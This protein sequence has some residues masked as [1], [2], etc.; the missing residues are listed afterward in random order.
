M[1]KENEGM[2]FVPEEDLNLHENFEPIIAENGVIGP[3]EEK[4]EEVPVPDAW[5]TRMDTV[6][7]LVALRSAQEKEKPKDEKPQGKKTMS[8]PQ[9]GEGERSPDEGGK[10]KIGEDLNPS[11]PA[12][13]AT[14]SVKVEG[15]P[16]QEKIRSREVVKQHAPRLEGREKKPKKEAVTIPLSSQ[17]PTPAPKKS[18]RWP[19][20]VAVLCFLFL[21]TITGIVPVEKIPFLR[22]LAYA[23]GFTK[24]D[25]ARMSFLRALLTWTDKTVGFSSSPEEG[26]SS[27]WARFFG[28]DTS[29][30]EREDLVGL[31]ARLERAGGKTSLIDIQA[32]NALQRQKGRA[33]DA[34]KNSALVNP[35][36]E[37]G[38]DP[39]AMRDTDVSVHTEANQDKN[40]V[41]FGSDATAAM[42]NFQDGYD[43]VN[44][45][46][47]LANP[48]IANGTPI[49]WLQNTAQRMMRSDVGLGGVNRGLQGTQV[50]W[51]NNTGG[52]GSGK[53][54]KDL[55]FAWITS[56]MAQKTPNL[57]L[58]KALVDTGFMGADFPTMASNVVDY[59]GIQIDMASFQEDQESWREYLEWEKKCKAEL[60]SSGRQVT[61]L[62]G[63][64]NNL[65]RDSGKWDFPQ[66]CAA[67][68][69]RNTPYEGT[70]FARNIGTIQTTC[71]Q[72]QRAYDSLIDTCHMSVR[73]HQNN[74]DARIN[75]SYAGYWQSFQN[76]CQAAFEQDFDVWWNQVKNTE[77]YLSQIQNN[78]EA[79]VKQNARSTYEN[80]QW[81][82]DGAKHTQENF[83]HE[84]VAPKIDK[85][86]GDNV[87]IDSMVDVVID[88]NGGSSDYFPSVD[89]TESVRNQL[90]ENKTI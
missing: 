51:G 49:D 83:V 63:D 74:C 32:L 40:D 86:Q 4:R 52:I 78:G 61:Q 80:G 33:L 72:L 17:N 41:F 44:T 57:M 28:T 2:P 18:R 70:N 1:S 22:N 26:R 65:V 60:D 45:L 39:A 81:K 58:K 55:Y 75:N 36:S 85:N 20:V 24:A 42:R 11:L 88:Q 73:T 3:S 71:K 31:Q 30:E 34:I 9:K 89:T 77:P 35:G 54:Q 7:D 46:K 6:Q 21:G 67:S 12:L 64:F 43:S 38:Q 90:G 76:Q 62:E 68:N 29:A 50:N 10:N 48:Y 84:V 82:I 5:A 27:L 16:Q 15:D 79:A 87:S 53:P 13:G 23:M 37:Q 69:A 14:P 47:K 25:T 59:G 66:N 56:R 8:L 19:W